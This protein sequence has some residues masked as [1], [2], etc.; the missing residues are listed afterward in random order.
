MTSTN[1]YSLALDWTERGLIP[2]KVIR[3]S[4]QAL[5]KRRLRDIQH[6]DAE[7]MAESKQSFIDKMNDS[8]IA[9]RTD[10]ANEQHYEVPAA[11]F[12]TVLGKHL[13]YSSC[14]WDETTED[15][16]AAEKKSLQQYCER[17]ELTNDQDILEL[18][19]GWGSLTLWM[20]E[21]YPGSRITAISNS[22]SQKSYI[23]QQAKVRK[24]TN[25]DVITCDMNAF[26]IARQFDRIVSIEMFEHMR[27]YRE[28][29][30]RVAD[31]LKPGGLFF[32]HI[33]VHRTCPYEFNDIDETDWM[34]RYFFTGGIM[35]SDD[36]P[37]HFQQDLK[38][39]KQWRWDGRHY[40][41][42]ANAWLKNMD[43]NRDKIMPIL[44]DVYGQGESEKWWMRWRIFFMACAELFGHDQGQQWWVSH[45]LFEKQPDGQG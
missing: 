36:L 12:Y 17:A 6:R 13:K 15:L 43:E 19:C 44:E 24:L 5:V 3:S 9:I 42:T 45:Y 28:L 2:D 27:N 40:E 22:V 41:K 18:G 32:K 31:W 8:K 35:P 34:S 23:M 7:R 39:K 33:F 20:A 1:V 14:F 29:Y 30:K 37:L 21:K 26:H 10:A 16:D 25:I 11:F 38:L 4:I